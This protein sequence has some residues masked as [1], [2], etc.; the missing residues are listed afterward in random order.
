M[1]APATFA[2]GSLVKDSLLVAR[3]EVKGDR[4]GLKVSVWVVICAIVLVLTSSKL[5]LTDE[6]PSPLEQS[7]M[8]YFVTSLATSLGLLVAGILAAD[9]GAEQKERAVQRTMVPTRY[10]ALLLGKV[11]SVMV[12]WLLIFVTCVPCIMVVGSGTGVS[13]AALVYTFVLGTLCVLGFATLTVGVGTLS[14]SERGVRL[15][16]LAIFIAMVSP[17]L[18][19]TALQ[20]S[21]FD[22][23]YNVLSPFA[24]A[25]L[26]LE[27]VI[28]DKE[29]LLVQLPYIGVLAMFAVIAGI[30]TACGVSL[31]RD[32]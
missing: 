32:E 30:F 12:A 19:G 21:P 6:E 31:E 10:G 28:L 4:Y 27:S 23:I 9:S 18:L 13:W 16:S 22:T 1:S 17:T 25:R 15:A 7:E 24:H 20:K 26:S 11:L 2:G 14:R 5:L 3:K 8:L 29:S